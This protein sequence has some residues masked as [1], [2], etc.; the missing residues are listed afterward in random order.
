MNCGHKRLISSVFKNED[1]KNLMK[2]VSEIVIKTVISGL[3]TLQNAYQLCNRND[4][5]SCF[6]LLGFDILLNDKK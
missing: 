4:P 3:P 5:N 2:K 6:Q 1:Y